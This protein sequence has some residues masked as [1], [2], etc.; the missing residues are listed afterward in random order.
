MASLTNIKETGGKGYNQ[1]HCIDYND[2]SPI[3]I[4]LLNNRGGCFSL[5]FIAET[6][7]PRNAS[8][9]TFGFKWQW[10]GREQRLQR[11]NEVRVRYS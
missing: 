5:T 9:A 11:K 6:M 1:K 7:F 2:F 8:T 4:I 3:A 10:C